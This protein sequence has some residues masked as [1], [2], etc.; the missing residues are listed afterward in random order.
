MILQDIILRNLLYEI[1][2]GA[3]VDINGSLLD[4]K[5]TFSIKS[6]IL[7]KLA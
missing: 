1:A 2:G 7:F 4:F 3:F 5:Y 6:N